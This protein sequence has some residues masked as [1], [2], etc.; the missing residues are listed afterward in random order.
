MV[1]LRHAKYRSYT[2]I[3]TEEDKHSQSDEV[4]HITLSL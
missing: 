4:N 2:Q 3:T 1:H